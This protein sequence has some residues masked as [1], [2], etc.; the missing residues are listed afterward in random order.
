MCF[1]QYLGEEG[2]ACPLKAAVVCSN[3]WNLDVGS[4]GLQSTWIGRE[5]YSKSMATGLKALV[6]KYVL[7]A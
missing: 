7:H 5:V 1:Q 2:E 4:T 3:P 6:E